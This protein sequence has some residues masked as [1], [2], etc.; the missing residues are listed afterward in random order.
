MLQRGLTLQQ[1]LL[2][3][4]PVSSPFFLLLPFFSFSFFITLTHTLKNANLRCEGQR[5]EPGLLALSSCMAG[6]GLLKRW[7]KQNMA[8]TKTPEGARPSWKH[9]IRETLRHLASP[10]TFYLVSTIYPSLC[11]PSLQKES[12]T[13]W[14]LAVDLHNRQKLPKNVIAPRRL[15]SINV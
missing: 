15:Y 4:M 6:I 10:T 2:M 12:Q 11:T 13:F 1:R 3:T 9:T 8:Q 14:M 5:P 7:Q